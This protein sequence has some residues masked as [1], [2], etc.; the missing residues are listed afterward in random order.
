MTSIKTQIAEL[1]RGADEILPEKGLE[2]KLKLGRRLALMPAMSCPK[3]SGVRC[4]KGP[5]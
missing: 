1:S 4:I 2:A 3:A 5:M